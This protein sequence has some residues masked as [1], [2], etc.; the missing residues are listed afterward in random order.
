LHATVD[1]PAA[2]MSHKQPGIRD[3]R[4]M[5]KQFHF[6]RINYEILI[7]TETGIC[8]LVSQLAT[9]TK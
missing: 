1:R 9:S 4:G 7:E 3:E 2:G 5:A 8:N 6:S